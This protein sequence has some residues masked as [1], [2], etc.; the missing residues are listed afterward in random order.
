LLI[1]KKKPILFAADFIDW[2]V[3]HIPTYDPLTNC[4]DL[5]ECLELAKEWSD[6]NPGH[7]PII[8]LLQNKADTDLTETEANTFD[9]MLM[10]IFSKGDI[11]K[12]GLELALFF[13]LCILADF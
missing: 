6:D 10:S 7:F 9:A 8:V 4:D 5:P 13:F 1:S 2:D 3:Y 12:P 11:I